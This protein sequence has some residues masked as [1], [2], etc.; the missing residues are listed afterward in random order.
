MT[1]ALDSRNGAGSST[2]VGAIDC[3]TNS[4][5]LLI[6][7]RTDGHL[8]NVVR[9][10]E[11]VR[12]GQDVDVTG[13][14]APEAMRR[15]LRMAEDY[16]ALCRQHHAEAVRFVATS[17]SR[18]ASNADE[19]VAGIRSAFT[20][21][22]IDPEVVSGDEEAALSFSG[23]T[24]DLL[25]GGA[26]AP[27]LVVDLGGGSTELVRGTRAVE[28]ARSVDIG[29]VRLTERHLKGDPPTGAQIAAALVDVHAALDR[30]EEVVDLTGIRTLVGLAGSV[31]TITAYALGLPKYD[32]SA[33]H[34]T[35]LPVETVIDAST[36]LLKMTREQRASLG[37]MHPGRVDVIGAGALVWRAIIERLVDRSGITDV[38][39]S[40]KDILDGIALSVHP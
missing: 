3:G 25:A 16:A 39:T 10:T 15:T 31:T 12:L 26:Q 37:F 4:I 17:A 32:S 7:D 23:A 24:G 30:A 9:R 33:I 34:G 27:Y 40:E 8:V 14:I 28:Q 18:D 20:G 19:F 36:Q 38:A 2:R 13:R 1:D 22:D 11:I 35:R 29:C 6:A 5:R 21:F